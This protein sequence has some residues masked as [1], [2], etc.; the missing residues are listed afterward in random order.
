MGK[1]K[2]K[3]LK[4]EKEGE[5]ALL[6]LDRLPAN[7]LNSEFMQEIIQA[8]QDL[9]HD[10]GVKALI[11][12]S[13]NSKYF[14]NGIDPEYMLARSISGRRE[15]FALLFQMLQ[16]L[17]TFPKPH[18][19]VIEGHAMAGGAVLGL[20]SDFRYMADNRS[21]YCFSEAAVG[22]TVPHALLAMMRAAIH[23]PYIN[24][25]VMQCHAFRPQEACKAGIVDF[26]FPPEDLL[27]RAKKDMQRLLRFS[28]PSLI[29]VKQ[30][31]R[32]PILEYMQKNREQA[33]VEIEKF[34][35]QE[36]EERMR[37]LLKRKEA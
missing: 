15:V 7:E 29:S 30:N 21:R 34:L 18:F 26:V 12:S 13:Y 22:L 33:L 11:L 2:Y 35:G 24:K 27:K 17:Y 4:E 32:T 31:L 19:A 16:V 8:H 36:F 20:I 14:C 9:A 25:A 28:L 23:A 10:E 5:T 6:F 1:D 3:Y 37:A